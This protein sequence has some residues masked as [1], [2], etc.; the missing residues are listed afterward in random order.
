[1]TKKMNLLYDL[2]TIPSS[3]WVLSSKF[4]FF[5]VFVFFQLQLVHFLYNVVMAFIFP[6]TG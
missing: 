3:S 4:L 5:L 2:E 6:V 1:M